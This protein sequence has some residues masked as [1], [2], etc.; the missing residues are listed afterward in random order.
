MNADIQSNK[1]NA[2]IAIVGGGIAG[3]T[4]ALYLGELG[5]DI[6]LIEK[7]P[8]LVN[9]PPFCHLHAGGNLYREIPEAL[10]LTLL[11]ESIDLL[12]FYPYAID[13][14]PTVI[15]VLQNDKG[16]P[17]DLIP[18]LKTLQAEYQRLIELDATNQVLGASEQ[19]FEL[20]SVA[21][22]EALKAEI[23]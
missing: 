2:R 16:L 14:H 3:A 17:Q 18:R 20:F 19:Y 11:R 1:K 21:Q 6:T 9:G 12:R 7:G 5:L 10:C 4:A 23:L 15:A 22:V 13:Y 8:T